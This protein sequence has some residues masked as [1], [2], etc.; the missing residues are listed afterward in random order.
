MADTPILNIS[1]I[2]VSFGGARILRGVGLKVREGKVVC[3]IGANGA[4][5]TTLLRTIAGLER[6]DAGTMIAFDRDITGARPKEILSLA[7]VVHSK[8]SGEWKG[9]GHGIGLS[10]FLVPVEFQCLF[11]LGKVWPERFADL[12]I[13]F[14]DIDN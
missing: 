13:F 8:Q 6:P 11:H 5:K 1:D 2:R 10:C 7:Y 9:S 12:A 4:G 3:L 14:V